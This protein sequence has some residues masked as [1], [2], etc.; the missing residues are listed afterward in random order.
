MKSFSLF[1]FLF[2]LFPIFLIGNKE[3]KA[4]FSMLNSGLNKRP[5]LC[6]KIKFVYTEQINRGLSTLK[7]ASLVRL[8]LTAVASVSA[9]NTLVELSNNELN[10]EL[11]PFP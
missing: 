7:S 6:N 3:K 1:F 4:Q 2:F 8:E 5:L 10:L 11:F 9:A